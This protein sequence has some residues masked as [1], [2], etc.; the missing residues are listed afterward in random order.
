MRMQLFAVALRAPGKDFYRR[1]H[2]CNALPRCNAPSCPYVYPRRYASS[3]FLFSSSSSSS[4]FESLNSLAKGLVANRVAV[5]TNNSLRRCSRVHL[6]LRTTHISHK[7]TIYIKSI[8][9]FY[10]LLYLY[11]AILYTAIFS[12]KFNLM[13]VG[14]S[15]TQ[16]YRY[17]LKQ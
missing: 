2:R 16:S 8:D 5:S 1:V 11:T 9:S 15:P 13:W 14:I 17:I 10:I 12:V 6:T 3:F 7:W 4:F